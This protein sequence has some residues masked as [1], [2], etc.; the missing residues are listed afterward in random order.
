MFISCFKLMKFETNVFFP[1]STECFS[2][3]IL[4]FHFIGGKVEKRS[5]RKLNEIKKKLQK[6]K[7][8]KI[9]RERE[10]NNKRFLQKV[11]FCPSSRYLTLIHFKNRFNWKV[12][13]SLCCEN[14]SRITIALSTR[15]A[16]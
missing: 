1:R 9:H 14:C 13:A 15:N 6:K 7:A 16:I 2:K 5:P 10:K 3:D 4:L 8:M 12:F 11:L